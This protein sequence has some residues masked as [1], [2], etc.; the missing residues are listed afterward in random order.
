MRSDERDFRRRTPGGGRSG[1]RTH[2]GHTPPGMGGDWRHCAG[3]NLRYFE[4]DGE[5]WFMPR[6]V[7][8]LFNRQQSVRD[9]IGLPKQMLSGL[10]R[11]ITFDEVCP[12]QLLD[13]PFDWE[14]PQ[15]EGTD[16]RLIPP[17][18]HGRLATLVMDP[19][20]LGD[21]QV[22]SVASRLGW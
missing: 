4:A 1:S 12:E 22:M 13:A 16:W 14:E 9:G 11:A 21:V 3:M 17:G 20:T 5:G 7:Y 8:Q 6:M 18:V 10:L 19:Q 15:L 2:E